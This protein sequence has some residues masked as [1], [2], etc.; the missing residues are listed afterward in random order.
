M[1][2]VGM[3]IGLTYHMACQEKYVE[4]H[5]P[6]YK[7]K[8]LSFLDPVQCYEYEHMKYSKYF[9]SGPFCLMIMMTIAMHSFLAK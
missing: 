5:N 7:S 9:G 4:S 3:G 8:G 2:N 1:L 6:K